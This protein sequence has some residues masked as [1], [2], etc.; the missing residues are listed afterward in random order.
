M[1]TLNLEQKKCQKIKKRSKIKEWG[2]I[3]FLFLCLG[4]NL[5]RFFTL[6]FGV[7]KDR[8]TERQNDVM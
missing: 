2:S 5:A 3:S 7:Q 6:H 4:P 1:S 8:E